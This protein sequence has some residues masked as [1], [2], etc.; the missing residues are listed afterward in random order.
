[1]SR[2][3]VTLAVF[4]VLSGSVKFV[5][6][7]IF[8]PSFYSNLNTGTDDNSV[9]PQN[10]ESVGT[11]SEDDFTAMRIE[12]IKN[13][14]LKK[15]RLKEKPQIAISD[16]P[17]PIQDN[18]NQLLSDHDTDLSMFDDDFYAKT[19]QAIV[20]PYEGIIWKF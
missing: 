16:L 20:L 3:V 7:G 4:L 6:G 18:E 11:I 8:P 9:D 5:T 2:L 10:D 19:T 13:Q 12:Y 1:M 14:I 15:L 17:K